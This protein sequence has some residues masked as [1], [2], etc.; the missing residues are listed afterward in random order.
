MSISR[1]AIVGTDPSFVDGK[2]KGDCSKTFERV[3]FQ[4][5]HPKHVGFPYGFHSQPQ[6]W[7]TEKNKTSRPCG[8]LCGIPSIR[9]LSFP[10]IAL[11]PSWWLTGG[12]GFASYKNRFFNTPDQSKPPTA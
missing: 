8:R 1:R 12:G 4:V 11:E 10:L 3:F 6:N 2:P 7:G 9:S 5:G